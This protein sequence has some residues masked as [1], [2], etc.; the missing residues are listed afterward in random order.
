M[1]TISTSTLMR[2]AEARDRF[3]H[4]NISRAF[5]RLNAAIAHYIEC[6]RDLENADCFDPA[7]QSWT[8]DAERARA[9]VLDL[10]GVITTAPVTRREDQPLKRSAMLTRAL[11]ECASGAAFTSLHR[12]LDNYAHLF[13]CLGGGAVAARVQQMLET[14]HGH[15]EALADLGEF[16]DPATSWSEAHEDECAPLTAVCAL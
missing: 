11:V 2:A 6:E 13:A 12:L 5:T 1:A 14:C 7:F 15:M 3:S 16:N 4:S 9:Q 10:A 8:S